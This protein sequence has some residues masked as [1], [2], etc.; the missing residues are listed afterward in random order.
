[1]YLREII[2]RFVKLKMHLPFALPMTQLF[3]VTEYHLK[4]T[5]ITCVQLKFTGKCIVIINLKL[6]WVR[7]KK[8]KIIFKAIL[9]VT[10]SH[11]KF[12]VHCG[13]GQRERFEFI[14]I[15]FFFF[16]SFYFCPMSG[17]SHD[18]WACKI[19]IFMFLNVFR[20]PHNWPWISH[21]SNNN[22]VV[23]SFAAKHTT[24]KKK[25]QKFIR[26]LPPWCIVI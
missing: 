12:Y 23:L 17:K 11:R 7:K 13:H 25:W 4:N 18:E 21:S 20:S 6:K 26:I 15:R 16:A 1:M 2:F 19:W 9:I 8:W 10:E 14:F 24:K 22:S 3:N 5:W